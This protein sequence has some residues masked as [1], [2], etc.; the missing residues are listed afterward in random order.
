[1][2]GGG[3]RGLIVVTHKLCIY[4]SASNLWNNELAVLMLSFEHYSLKFLDSILQEG[5]QDSSL[6]TARAHD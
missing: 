5:P 2:Q 6:V 3:E 4:V 1:M